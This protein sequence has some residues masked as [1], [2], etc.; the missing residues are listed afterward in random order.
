ME[1]MRQQMHER[2]ALEVL[3][4]TP[5]VKINAL[6]NNLKDGG[7]FSYLAK[8]HAQS[9]DELLK[10]AEKYVTRKLKLSLWL[11][12]RGRN[13]YLSGRLQIRLRD[14]DLGPE[15]DMKSIHL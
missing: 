8:K 11:Q 6:T 7:L 14:L 3:S 9:F 1:V 2:A 5:E 12:K 15:Q 10:R 4:V 13:R